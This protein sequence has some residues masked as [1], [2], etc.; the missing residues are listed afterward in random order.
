MSLTSVQKL[1]QPI[2]FLK[3][4]GP[5]RADLLKKELGIF[6]YEDLLNYFPFRH[7]DRTRV[8]TISELKQ[9]EDFAQVAGVVLQA[10]VI[11]QRAS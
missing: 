10:E 4:V 8:S 9:E 6:T 2:E 3:G 11:G 1:Q 5:L 7:I